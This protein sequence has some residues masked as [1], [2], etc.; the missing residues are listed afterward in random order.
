MKASLY[1]PSFPLFCY[2]VY[3]LYIILYYEALC[4]VW[5]DMS[6]IDLSIIIFLTINN[7]AISPLMNN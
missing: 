7:S 2:H 5:L 3:D 1:F 6:A 4:K